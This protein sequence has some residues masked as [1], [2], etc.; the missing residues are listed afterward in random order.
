MVED[1]MITADAAGVGAVKPEGLPGAKTG[2]AD[3]AA[4]GSPPAIVLQRP[5]SRDL[6]SKKGAMTL[7]KRLQGYWYE[8]GYPSARF[9]AEPIEERFEKI[10][11]YELH[12]V[13]SNLVNG[14]PPRYCDDP[15]PRR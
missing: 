4:S 7:A 11:T 13:A 3:L 8:R 14:L 5:S 6:L 12:R 2:V 15:P 10:G 9:W 1:D